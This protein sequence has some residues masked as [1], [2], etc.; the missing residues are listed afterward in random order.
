[1][2]QVSDT[3]RAFVEETVSCS[4]ALWNAVQEG[5]CHPFFEVLSLKMQRL[6]GSMRLQTRLYPLVPLDLL[7]FLGL[8]APGPPGSLISPENHPTNP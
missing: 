4:A 3:V 5:V 2:T 8:W 1:M 7:F 6:L